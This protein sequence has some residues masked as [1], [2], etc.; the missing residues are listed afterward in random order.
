MV[1]ATHAALQLAPMTRS[2][3]VRDGRRFDGAK[4]GPPNHIGGKDSTGG[5]CSTR[6]WV[7]DVA[8]IGHD[9]GSFPKG[10]CRGADGP[11]RRNARKT[12]SISQSTRGGLLPHACA[13][14]IARPSFGGNGLERQRRA[15]TLAD[16]STI[17][18]R[19]RRTGARDFSTANRIV[20]R[21]RPR[22]IAKSRTPDGSII[23]RGGN[24][25]AETRGA[26]GSTASL[27]RRVWFGITTSCTFARKD[28][29]LKRH[30]SSWF[31]E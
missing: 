12:R 5:C 29:K 22:L 8:S 18:L 15:D 31:F 2:V 13:R 7:V 17:A 10:A 27:G 26:I 28:G 21:R 6:A 4:R 19:L 30:S 3:V 16:G 14:R 25:K 11:I 23:S 1:F 24:T 20:P 9:V